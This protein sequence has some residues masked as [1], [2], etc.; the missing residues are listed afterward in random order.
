MVSFPSCFCGFAWEIC[1]DPRWYSFTSN[2]SF[3]YAAFNILSLFLVFRSLNMMY[4][5][6]S[7]M[8][9]QVKDLAL[10]LR[11]LGHCCGWSSASGPGTSACWGYRQKKQ[12][13][14]YMIYLG[15]ALFDF[16]LLGIHLTSCIYIFM[17][18]QIWDIFKYYFFEYFFCPTF[19]PLY[20]WNSM[21]QRWDPLLLSH[22]ARGSIP[23]FP[24]FFF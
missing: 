22:R 1:W 14:K 5:R 7:L 16:I 12:N 15:V 4:R 11:G 13:K 6:S 17:S 23:F 9:Q 10:S 21:V 8:A 2:V 20:F 18:H 24:I 19:F 3:L